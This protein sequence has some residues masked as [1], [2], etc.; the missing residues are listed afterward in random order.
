MFFHS[1]GVEKNDQSFTLRSW[2]PSKFINGGMTIKE[3]NETM[4]IHRPKCVWTALLL[5]FDSSSIIVSQLFLCYS[6]IY[7]F[8]VLSI[9]NESLHKISQ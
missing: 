2:N 7:G 8:D 5:H 3:I 6:D 1:L 4:T 9:L